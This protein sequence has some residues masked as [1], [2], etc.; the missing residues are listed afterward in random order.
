MTWQ[1]FD[2]DFKG[3]PSQVL[4]DDSYSQE[5]PG[6]ELPNLARFSIWFQQTPPEEAYVN[7]DEADAVEKLEKDL[8]GIA[9]HFGQ[10]WVVYVRR[11]DMPGLREYD[12]YYGGD[13]DLSQVVPML[14]EANPGYRVEFE[15]SADPGW[16]QYLSWLPVGG[17]G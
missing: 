13:A 3:I 1:L 4:L 17:Q 16:N 10:G 2:T 9:N 6:E 12:L 14:T 8:L 11:L 5:I 7:A 15:H